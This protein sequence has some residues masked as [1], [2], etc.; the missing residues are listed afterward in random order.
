MTRHVATGAPL[1][2][3]LTLHP[4]NSQ[5]IAIPMDPFGYKIF[6]LSC[7][8]QLHLWFRELPAPS[9]TFGSP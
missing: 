3:H 2:L 4:L 1:A 9:D 6:D 7:A 8:R 5:P